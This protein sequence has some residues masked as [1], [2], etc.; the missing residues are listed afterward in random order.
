MNTCGK[1][2][3]EAEARSKSLA[4]EVFEPWDWIISASAYKAEFYQIVK[5]QVEESIENKI[6]SILI[7]QTGY[8]YVLAATGQNKGDYIVSFKR[9]RDGE[10]IW[11]AKDSDGN[12][13]IRTIINEAVVLKPG[14]TTTL[15][16]PWKNQGEQTARM[17]MVKIAYF[18][19]WDWVIGAGAYQDELESAV[20]KSEEK[21]N[22]AMFQIVGAGLILLLAGIILAIFL[23]RGITRPI[24]RIIDSLAAGADEVSSAS[25]QV[26][27]ASHSL[28]EGASEQAAAIE[29]T[30]A[31][32][33]EMS[34][35]TKQNADNASQ[36]NNLMRE[37][38]TVV[39]KAGH[40]MTQMNESMSEISSVGQEIGKIIRTIDEIAFQTNLLALNAAVEAARAGEAGAGFAVVADEV[41][42][43]AQR[44]AEAAKNTANLIEGTITR[45]NQ[46]TEL[47]RTT[48]EAFSEV[49]KLSG[50]VAEFIGEIAASSSEQ[51]QG[52][53]QLNQAVTQMDQ[54]TQSNAA[55]AEESASGFGRAQRPGQGNA[56]CG[57]RSDNPGS[58]GSAQPLS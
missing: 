46:G 35:M 37:A 28:A 54:V 15:T 4:Q 55:S 47:V 25:D 16:Y 23:V 2:R 51:S 41:R 33:E 44:A 9:E 5:K 49:A 17:K 50:K 14:Q 58:A 12:Y 31:S 19:P 6:A 3:G 27:S 10:N 38:N 45:I 18:Q 8:A 36:A 26:S 53:D 43:L 42:N 32:L 13:F 1:T 29:E 21:F 34:S 30:S 20:T 40:S 22:S 24:T 11:D 48:D 52:I 7:G 39:E 56:R 57:G